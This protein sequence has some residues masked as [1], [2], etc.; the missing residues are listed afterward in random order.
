MPNVNLITPPDKLLNNNI[1]VLNVYPSDSLKEE[2]KDVLRGITEDINLYL[3][4]NQA[5]IDHE[6]LLN[7]VKICDY[8]IIDFD[9]CDEKVRELKSYFLTQNNVY[10]L[11]NSMEPYYNLL[12]VNRIYNL[13]WFKGALLTHEKK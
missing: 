1:S 11:T 6:W 12:S 2:W 8:V 13:D 7:I 10:W 4:E 5:Q 3:Y 9:N